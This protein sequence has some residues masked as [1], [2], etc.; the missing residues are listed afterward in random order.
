MDKLLEFSVIGISTLDP[1][2]VFMKFFNAANKVGYGFG[3]D[4]AF[5]N[6]DEAKSMFYDDKN[7]KDP[8]YRYFDYVNGKRLKLI[9]KKDDSILDYIEY[10]VFYG[11]DLCDGLIKELFNE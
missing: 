6:Y 7:S 8:R 11:K 1:V 5:V 3:H 2:L 9:F 10:E 4:K